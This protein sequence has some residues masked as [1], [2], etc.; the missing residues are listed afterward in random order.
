M[1]EQ[2]RALKIEFG[3]GKQK[4]RPCPSIVATSFLDL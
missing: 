2:G 4:E 1:T 3:P